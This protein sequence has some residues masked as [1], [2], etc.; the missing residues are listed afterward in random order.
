MET[1]FKELKEEIIK[2]AKA[3][4]ACTSEYKRAYKSESFEELLQVIKDNFDF[5][6][7]RKVIDIELI[8]LYENEFNNNKIYGNIDISEGYLLV[9]N[10]TVRAWGNATVRAWGNA[11]VEAWGNATVE[12]SGNATVEASGNATVRASDSATVEASGNATVRASGNATVEA[13]GNATVEASGNAT[14]RAS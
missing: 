10:A 7:R 1:N 12:A 13:W 14:V 8:K 2:R 9:D 6:V 11:T 4:D 5:A 3:A